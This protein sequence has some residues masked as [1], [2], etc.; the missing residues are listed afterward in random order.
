MTAMPSWSPG[1]P[2]AI[3]RR[4]TTDGV[5]GITPFRSM[6][7]ATQPAHHLDPPEI[8]LRFRVGEVHIVLEPAATS[9]VDHFV[10]ITGKRLKR[11]GYSC[12]PPYSTE[13]AG[14]ADGRGRVVAR[15]KKFRRPASEPQLQ[16]YTMIRPY[17]LVLT[18]AEGQAGRAR[19]FGPIM[20]DA[21]VAP[22]INPVV[23]LLAADRSPVEET[24]VLTRRNA[25][26]TAVISPR[27]V[28]TSNDEFAM[29]SLEN[30]RSRLPNMA[31]GDWQPDV[32]LGGRPCVRH[33]FVHGGVQAGGVVR[34][35]FWWAGVV[36]ERG[37][38][39]FVLGTKSIIDQDQARRLQDLV[40]LVPSS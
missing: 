21:P 35:E 23:R 18:V 25:R 1:D 15:K 28:T 14:F 4:R 17:S 7:G 5:P 29:A 39:I 36:A 2:E 12:G 11:R 10:D 30:I 22:A 27:P 3:A 32:F 8:S 40:V 31:V 37:I 33:T 9:S 19:E 24:I 26:L 6:L 38:Q 16:L 13:V 20:L 34:S